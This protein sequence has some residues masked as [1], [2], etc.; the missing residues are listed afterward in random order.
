MRKLNPALVISVIA[1]FIALGGAGWAATGGNL[2]LGKS[3][4]ATSTT[5]LSAPTGGKALQITN[6]STGTGATALGL[7]VA[8]GHPPFTV[9]SNV[10]VPDLNADRLDGF[11]SSGLQRRVSGTCA[12]RSAL[13]AVASNG[14]VTCQATGL[15][16]YQMV[17][18]SISGG[19]AQVTGQADC[20]DGKV[21]VGGGATAS[22]I[23]NMPSADGT[24]P[25]MYDSHV[26]GGG[27]FAGFLA[28]AAY[29]GH[30]GIIV[31][32]VCVDG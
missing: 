16:G 20:P 31:Y 27:W 18:K 8:S 19:T 22:G 10:K 13:R 9:N 30:Y 2:I 26:S 1:L 5:S 6:G 7:S 24:G 28:S 25:H 32:V 12:G 29:A 11:D 3:N 21:P 17:T 23:I 14:T 15:T 4:S